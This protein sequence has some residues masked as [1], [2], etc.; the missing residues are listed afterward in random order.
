MIGGVNRKSL[1][2]SFGVLASIG[3]NLVA[4]IHVAS[5]H[6]V[7]THLEIM[8]K[9][10]IDDFAYIFLAPSGVHPNASYAGMRVLITP[11]H[12]MVEMPGDWEVD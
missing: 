9:L 10:G 4:V 8:E 3:C 11:S 7:R 6:R 5:A 1:D 2:T 12:R